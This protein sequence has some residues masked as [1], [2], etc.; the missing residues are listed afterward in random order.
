VRLVV[1]NKFLSEDEV[2][3]K[4][5]DAGCVQ[6]GKELGTSRLWEAPGGRA[7]YVPKGDLPARMVKRIVQYVVSRENQWLHGKPQNP[8]AK[9]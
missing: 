5:R 1:R 8:D 4:L 6:T 3:A 7:F 2:E 9:D